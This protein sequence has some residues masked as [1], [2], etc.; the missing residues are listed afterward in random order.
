MHHFTI[1]LMR[2]YY[3]KEAYLNITIATGIE[4]GVASCVTNN[5]TMHYR[6]SREP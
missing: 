5:F 6:A 1:K 3:S 2:K 4:P